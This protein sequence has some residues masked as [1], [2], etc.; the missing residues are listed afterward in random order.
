MRR[1]IVRVV[2]ALALLVAPVGVAY[3]EDPEW[4]VFRPDG[5]GFEVEMH[6][7]PQHRRDEGRSLLGRVVHEYYWVERA[8][9]KLDVE[10]HQL[11][12]LATV[13]LSTEGLLDRI[14]ADLMKDLDTEPTHAEEISLQGHPGRRVVYA[15]GEPVPSP[16]ETRLYLVGRT[17]FVVATGA[18]LPETRGPIVDRFFASFRIIE[19]DLEE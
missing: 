8:G 15:R 7:E 10:R 1:V 12:R 3:A 4:R 16:E 9:A 11:P 18:Y 19:A 2:A 17:L 5:G 14:Q 13:F 6:G